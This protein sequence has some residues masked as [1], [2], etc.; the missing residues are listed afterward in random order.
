MFIKKVSWTTKMYCKEKKKIDENLDYN[1]LIKQEID[2]NLLKE[3]F[4]E[5]QEFF[6]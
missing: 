3:K 5:S 4:D 6:K 1:H 2:Y